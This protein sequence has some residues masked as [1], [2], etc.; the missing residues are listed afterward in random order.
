MPPA[1]RPTPSPI[2]MR[3]LPVAE[4]GVPDLRSKDRFLLWIGRAQ[5]RPLSLG[6][7]WG[8]LWMGSQ[9]A[10]PA[11]LGL[12]VQAAVDSDARMVLM[13]AKHHGGG[14]IS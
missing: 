12:G 14:L 7:L 9:A 6:V 5:A 2:A 11:A 8:V 10:I 13:Q 3:D 4:P 1:T